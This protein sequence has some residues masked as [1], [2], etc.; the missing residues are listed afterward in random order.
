PTPKD[1]WLAQSLISGTEFSAYAIAWRG[2]IVARSIYRNFLRAGQGTG[3]CYGGVSARDIEDFLARFAAKTNWHGQVSFDFIRPENGP[4]V[5]IECNPR[6]TSGLSLFSADDGVVPAIIEG[7]PAAIPSRTQLAIKGTTFLAGVFGWLG[8]APRQAWVKYFLSSEDALSFPGDGTLLH[9]Q[10]MSV[11][12]LFL[13]SLR[14][15]C[16]ILEAATYDM[17]W[18]GFEG[19]NLSKSTVPPARHRAAGPQHMPAK[20]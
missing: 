1:P 4:L 19:G 8:L 3:I 5:A 6:A 18:N 14:Q 13:L 17:D 2:R 10:T 20:K 9:G 11:A 16:S 12:E 15:N 7:S